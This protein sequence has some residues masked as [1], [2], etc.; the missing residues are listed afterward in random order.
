M[1]LAVFDVDSTLI[2]AET[3]EKLAMVVGLE[4]KVREVTTRAMQ[5]ELDFFES[6][7]YRVGLLKGVDVEKVNH[8]CENLPLMNGAIELI[9]ELKNRGYIVVCFSGGFKNATV[10]LMKKLGL[11]AEF[12]NILHEKDGKLTGL[13]GGEMMFNNSKSLMLQKIQKLLNISPEDTIAIGDGA[14]DLGMF[15]HAKTKVAFCAKEI[16]KKNANVIIETKD[17]REVLKYI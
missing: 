14:N 5:G 8:I 11:D 9:Q 15:E 2:D 12:A 4:E 10:P 6:L 17:L 16:L 3:I 7:T 1:K 13:V